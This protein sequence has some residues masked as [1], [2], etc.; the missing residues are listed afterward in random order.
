VLGESQKHEN[1]APPPAA[2]EVA[3]SEAPRAQ[4]A[5]PPPERAKVAETAPADHKAPQPD[6]PKVDPAKAP[7]ATG[8]CKLNVNSIPVSKILL[9]G[10]PIGLTPKVGV[11]VPAGSHT[12]VFVGENARK[13][14]SSTCQ[15]GE[16]K[17]VSMHL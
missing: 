3:P 13:S 17:A 4:A 10:K 14:T 6:A 1:A 5:A 11:V 7:V 16:T 8:S 15:P 2:P 12:V 9:D